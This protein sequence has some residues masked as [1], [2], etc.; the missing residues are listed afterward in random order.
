MIVTTR[1]SEP[2]A[3]A[4]R[5][6]AGPAYVQRR[7]RI[8]EYARMIDAGILGEDDHVELLEGMLVQD[9]PQG[10]PHAN[11]IV[12]L[13]KALVLAAGNEFTVRP[14][15]PLTLGDFSE[16]EPDLAVVRVSDAASRKQHPRTALLVVEVSGDSLRKD[17]GIKAA[18]Y[19]GAGIPNYWIV[20]VDAGS[21]EV[22]GDPDAGAR[23][24]RRLVTLQREAT[25][26]VE[27]L[28]GLSL[29]VAALFD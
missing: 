2:P 4:D 10:P 16:P 22:Y 7:L 25:L 15:V 28:P 6:T 11:V 5:E 19:A 1:P 14:Q 3:A 8:D 29:L 24:Y 27:G 20:N 9:S 18:I 26:E 23:R 13:T 12:A 17:R 21:V